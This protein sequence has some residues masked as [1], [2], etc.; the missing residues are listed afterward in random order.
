MS[1]IPAILLFLYI[2]L[3][4]GEQILLLCG[5]IQ[6]VLTCSGIGFRLCFQC[7]GLLN[8][9]C[10]ILSHLMS[11]LAQVFVNGKTR[12]PTFC[13]S[14]A[15]VFFISFSSFEI[16]TVK[17]IHIPSALAHQGGE[18][19]IDFDKELCIDKISAIAVSYTHL[20]WADSPQGR[21]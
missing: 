20:P 16:G 11:F 7:F 4:A 13:V 21:W 6:L 18:T 10:G 9:L 15:G 2:F 8:K 17:V 12:L 5:Q 14:L 19:L 1:F 3:L